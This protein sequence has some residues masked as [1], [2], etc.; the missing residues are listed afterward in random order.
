MSEALKLTAYVGERDRVEGHLLSD[1][2]LDA[3][4]RAD[5]RIAALFR[6]AEGF[7]VKHQL[8]TQRLLT[9]SEDLPLVAVAVDGRDRIE[10]LLPAVKRLVEGGLITL[11]RVRVLAD[12]PSPVATPHGKHKLTVYV[13]RRQRA[14][15]LPAHVAVV[16]AMHRAGFDGATALLA[17]DGVVRG[18]RQRARFLSANAGVPVAVVGIGDAGAVAAALPAIHAAA[19]DAPATLERVRLCGHGGRRLAAAGAPEADGAARERWQKLTVHTVEGAR[20]GPQALHV[21]LLHRLRLEGA[22]GATVLRG[23]WGYAAGRQPHGDRL[24]SIRRGV[25]VVTVLVDTPE[26]T[27]GWLGVVDEVTGAHGLVTSEIVPAL[28]AVGPGIERGG[29]E[30]ADAPV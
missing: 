1:V 17:V 23:V 3:L 6:A 30:L 22:L 28:L 20:H 10:S 12:E 29:L 9:L 15:G 16:E 26:R 5:V 4:D 18:R 25:P 13:G 11:E 19:G 24:R 27:R 21:A 14:G 2:L 8:H 7:G